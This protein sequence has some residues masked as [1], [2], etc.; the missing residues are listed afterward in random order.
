MPPP[1]D[2]IEDELRRAA[3]SRRYP[4]VTRLAAE[5]GK[6][7]EAKVQDLPQGDPRAAEVARKLDDLLSWALVMMK[8]ARSDCAAELLRLNTATI[9]NHP[10]GE[11]AP[12]VRLDA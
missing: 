10:I 7:A 4:D 8:A 11:R 3:A 9:Y 1:L 5:F 12:A 6:A 2:R